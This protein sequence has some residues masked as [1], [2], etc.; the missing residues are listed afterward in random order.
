MSHDKIEPL[1]DGITRRDFVLTT[2]TAGGGLMMGGSAWGQDAQTAPL[3]KRGDE[4]ALAIIGVGSQGGNLLNKCLK[5]PGVRFV[6]VCDIWPYWLSR[7]RKLLERYDQDVNTYV[8][9]REMLEQERNID[10][11]IVATPDWVHAEQAV[12]CLEAGKHVYCEKEMSNTLEGARQMVK[13]AR[14][15]GKLLQIGHQ[16]RSNP[17]YGHAIKLIEKDK[18]LGR[19][20]HCYGQ[21][22]R[23]QLLERRWPQKHELATAP[24]EIPN[25]NSGE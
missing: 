16:R 22:N 7:Y 1:P 17:R 19:I 11:V 10:A 20:T 4:L 9:Y 21:W 12:S 15:T 13:A 18:I 14:R 24:N 23:A 3:V 8:D 5:I 2:A 25:G 6:A